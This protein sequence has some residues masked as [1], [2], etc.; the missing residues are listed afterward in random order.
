M[1]ALVIANW[2]MNP[3][4][5]ADAKKLFEAT[6]KAADKARKV[7][8]V[9]APPVIFLE[10][11]TAGYRGKRL[12]FGIQN[13]HPDTNGSHTGEISLVQAQDAGATWAIIG[14]AE[15]RAMGETSEDTQKKVLAA[16]ALKMTPVLCIGE[17]T[18]DSSGE[19]LQVVKEQ[20][21]IGLAEVPAAKL[22]KIVIAYEPVW[23]IGATSAM[24]PHDM[25]EMAIFIR[26][27]L[28]DIYGKPG[29]S[30]K[31]LYGGS[32]NE[33]NAPDMMHEGDVEGLL[34]GR[35]SSDAKQ[36]ALLLNAIEKA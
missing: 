26:K 1:K 36:F 24:K 34:V 18:R 22:T 3:E 6:K 25:H 8:I 33:E 35:G 11:L 2:K 14:H 21:K 4:K 20:L 12:A 29:L 27:T 5:L 30:I 17:K 19:H 15:R 28:F 9:V 7:T 16:L 32:I 13:A 23:A 31:I 10:T